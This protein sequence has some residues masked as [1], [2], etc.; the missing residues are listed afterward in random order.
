ML[1][2]P[3]L[4]EGF[5]M[6]ILEAQIRETPV[7]TSNVPSI[8]EIAGAGALLIDPLSVEELH[9][10]IY[11]IISDKN[12]KNDLIAKG[13]SNIQRFSWLKCAQQTL[14]VLTRD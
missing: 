10:S 11:K 6:P 7:V 9:S 13:L 1:V 14:E 4:Y 12:F 2:F 8:I 5:G 3:T